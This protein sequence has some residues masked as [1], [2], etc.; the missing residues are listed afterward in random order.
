MQSLINTV[1]L[2]RWMKHRKGCDSTR[3]ALLD[4]TPLTLCL[5]PNT[6]Q[7]LTPPVYG[8]KGY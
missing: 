8:Y 7:N 6:E 2:G 4:P 3:T 5:A 1:M